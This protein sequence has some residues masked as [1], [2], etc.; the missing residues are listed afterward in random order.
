MMKTLTNFELFSI[1]L[2][3]VLIYATYIS[4]KK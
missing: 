2:T 4:A 3:M 1:I